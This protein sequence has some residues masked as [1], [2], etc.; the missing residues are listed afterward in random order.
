MKFQMYQNNFGAD[1]ITYINLICLRIAIGERP[2]GAYCLKALIGN[3]SFHKD[4]KC[5]YISF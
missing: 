3:F 1:L 5:E 2:N 4:I